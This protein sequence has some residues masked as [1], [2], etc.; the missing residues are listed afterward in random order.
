MKKDEK[1]EEIENIKIK[2]EQPLICP[3][4]H[5]INDKSSKFCIFCH[6]KLNN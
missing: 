4:C 2:F 1:K 6:S 3:I 5:H